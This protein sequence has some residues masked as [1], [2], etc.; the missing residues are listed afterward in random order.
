MSRGITPVKMAL[1][2]TCLAEKRII[3]SATSLH[4]YYRSGDSLLKVLRGVDFTLYEGEIVS[5]VGPS[6]SGKSTFLH[7]LGGL[8][9]PTEGEIVIDSRDLNLIT[10]EELSAVRNSKIGF[11]FQFHHLLRD[12]TALENVMMPLLIAGRPRGEARE[13]AAAMLESMGVADRRNHKPLELSGGEQQRVAVARAL[14]GSPMM[15]LADE[16]T[17]NLDREN[18]EEL[19]EMMIRISREKKI[20]FVIVTHNENLAGRANRIFRLMDGTLHPQIH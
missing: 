13:N 9:R 3:L 5:I 8:D 14:I 18:S 12:F 10:E 11:I 4:K 19:H 6:G 1:R 15:V 16:P 17:G 20:S 7:L 2:E